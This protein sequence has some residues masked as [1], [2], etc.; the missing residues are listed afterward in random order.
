MKQV[1]TEEKSK[2]YSEITDIVSGKI[3][4]YCVRGNVRRKKRL[5]VSGTTDLADTGKLL[6]LHHPHDPTCSKESCHFYYHKAGAPLRCFECVRT[7]RAADYMGYQYP[8]VIFDI[9]RR[10]FPR[11]ETP[12]DSSATFSFQRKQR[13]YSA[14]VLDISLQGIRLAV[15]YPGEV[16]AGDILNPISLTLFKRFDTNEEIIIQLEQAEVKRSMGDG[17]HT[18]E[19]GLEFKVSGKEEDVL[20]SYIDIRQIEDSVNSKRSS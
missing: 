2:I 3:G 7:K 6:I 15:D 11:V 4:L 10:R 17:E 14:Q 12:N 5:R 9:Q 8:S 18:N 16:N 20:A 19:L 1:W 13:I